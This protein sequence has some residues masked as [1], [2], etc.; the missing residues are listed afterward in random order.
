MD[1]TDR[2]PDPAAAAPSGPAASPTTPA[3][4]GLV[5][6]A[7]VLALLALLAALAGVA[8]WS[9]RSER[10]SAWLL[11]LVPGL[12]VD[13]PRGALLG[14]DF[15][16]Q[17]VVI[18]LPGGKDTVT[19]TG[20]A[21]RGLRI[22]RASSPRWLHVTL[23][24]LEMRR[25]DLAFAPGGDATPP[26]PPADLRL[27]IEF[28]LTALQVGELHASAL[29]AQPLREL[30]ARL[31][32]GADGGAEHRLEQLALTWDRLQASGD[33]RIASVAPM[34][35]NASLQLVQSAAAA[36]PAWTASATL[37]GPLAEPVLQATLRAD[38]PT[39]G[40]EA[41]ARPAQSLDAHAT[42]R[43]FARWPLG[44]LRASVRALDL[45][46]FASAAPATALTGEAVATS[47][48]ADQP[49]T[50]SIVLNNELPGRWSDAR[51]PLHRLVLKLVG[52]PDQPG[53]LTLQDLAAELGTPEAG[54]GRIGAHGRWS[55]DGW[56]IEAALDEVQ[57]ARLDARAPTMRLS[58]PLTAAGG[59]A[60]A[61]NRID[62]LGAVA[63]RLDERGTARAVQLKLDARID[64]TADATRIELRDAQAQ[65]NGARASL[66]GLVTHTARDAPW[67]VQ[68]KA[69][70]V[71][72]D[73]AVW[74]PGRDDA[75]WRRARNRLNARGD[76]DLSLP[77]TALDSAPLAMLAALRGQAALTLARSELAG[78]PLSGS[79]SLR[80]SAGAPL[81]SALE[82]DADGNRLHATGRFDT[83]GNG[84]A[85]RWDLTIDG[86]ALTRLAPVWRLL[87]PAGSDATLAGSLNGQAQLTG[88]WPALTTQGQLDA[89]ALRIGAAALQ[90]ATARWSLGSSANAP[91]EAQ[92]S[93]TQAA[94]AGGGA[95]GGA[96]GPSI[97]S[98]QLQLSGTGRAHTL[99]LRA[100]SKGRPPAWAD[101]AMAGGAAAAGNARTIAVLQAQGGLV[102]LPGAALA[103]WRGTL[104]QL[105]LRSSAAGATPLLHTSDV[106]LEALWGGGPARASVQ[107]GRA[108]LLGGA[109]RWSRITWQAA[110][111]PDGAAQIDAEAEIEPLRIAPILARA[112]PDFGW[113]GDLAIAGH[114]KLRSAPT[115]QADIVIER[116]AGDLSVTDELGTRALGLTDLRFG[117]SA[118]NGV[119]NFTQGLAGQT[120]GVAA[121]A[122]VVN[123]TPQAIWPAAD[124]PIHG[125]LELR[126]ADLGTWG[127]WVPPGW[128]IEGALH[129]SASIGGRFG[130]PEYT[131]AVDGTRLAVRNFLEGVNVSEGNVAIRLQGT[132]ARIEHF[133]AKAGSGSLR[134]DGSA[135][136]GAAPKAV[137]QLQADK[138]QLLGRIDRR[139]VTSGQGRLELD[140]TALAF[141][142]RFDVDEGLID[143]TRSDAPSLGSD[144]VVVRAPGVASP[145][146]AASAAA[147]PA[148]AAVPTPAARQ[149][150]L[151][152]RVALG[153]KLRLRG[154]GLD[155]GLRGELHITSPGGRLA[156]NGAVRATDGTYAA[157]GQK[158]TIDRGL[159]S[160]N[161]P[162]EN[163]RLDI[164]ATRPNID[165]RVGVAVGGS[166]A[167]PRVRLI[168]EPE[169]SEIDKLSWL[170]MGRASD[171][172][173]RTDT[174]LLQRAALALLAGEGGGPTDQLTK[175]LGLDD[176]S[177]RQSDGEVRETVVALGKQLSR[178]WYVGYEH[179]LNATSGSFQLIY[180]I[181][182]RFTLR[183][184]S[185]EDNSLDVIWTWRWQ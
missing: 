26:T 25:L 174:A 27:P 42:L 97:E 173:G 105:D 180:R 15:D 179:G 125:V 96:A 138:F 13:G 43:P 148:A 45:S 31:H 184:Q 39:R 119:W 100:E 161:G 112:Q 156:I 49:A 150:A 137:L 21:W 164:E 34:R 6:L 12:Q 111:T 14:G 165:V 128:R 81:V 127:P 181:A 98:A 68:A 142:G 115:F 110:A 28:E 89:K 151:D 133:S 123:T 121:G 51:L 132:S 80:S 85:D 109:L 73:P 37:A 103:G 4:R 67:T 19:V 74:W 9:V 54:A 145:A 22:A 166:A 101:A 131:G 172:L 78:V 153:E 144:V 59:A 38:A 176:I 177:V 122:V 135:S 83:H 104:R 48:A 77:A 140:S 113:G 159:I 52:R 7:A 130:A 63:G 79:A 23:A 46:G 149:V 175:A 157:Y 124:A 120:V 182:R 162:I 70:L 18:R 88:R 20:L 183:A 87:Q 30:H 94:V 11:S 91:I 90:S 35:L 53:A 117:L 17:R 8:W 92:I 33:A 86:P 106:A 60:A 71:D 160:F 139:I 155:T 185:G 134:V 143:F 126:V 84:A 141:D 62:I 170:V 152:L 116:R 36:L 72:F 146:A 154:R 163:P 99:T 55:A 147:T 1:P 66:T 41:A 50:V 16:A 65:T 93:V 69:A 2:V 44:E 10:G 107:P 24:S 102:D 3:R 58:G 61:P 158:L 29:G 108:E 76:I 171:G 64:A 118:D 75:P 82:L 56:T 169:M 167:N 136:L 178:R 32:L 47:S 168:S 40:N 95:G 114:L 5:W 129:S 57:P